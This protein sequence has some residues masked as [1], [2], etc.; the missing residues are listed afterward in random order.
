MVLNTPKRNPRL[1]CTCWCRYIGIFCLVPLV[2]I[3]YMGSWNQAD[4]GMCERSGTAHHHGFKKMILRFEHS[5][6]EWVQLGNGVQICCVDG[7]FWGYTVGFSCEV[8]GRVIAELPPVCQSPWSASEI[9]PNVLEI[10]ISFRT[11]VF[12]LLSVFNIC[13]Y[14]HF[15][16]TTDLPVD[17]TDLA[18][19]LAVA[20]SYQHTVQTS[21]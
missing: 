12:Q 1:Y 5:F 18:Y 3:G 8:Q 20:R 6:S 4:R 2:G 14:L 10:Q 16:N 9:T 13:M 15:L 7:L 11:K 21:F 19:S 17:C